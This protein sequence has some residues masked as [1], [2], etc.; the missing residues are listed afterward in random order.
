MQQAEILFFK[1]YN[2][3]SLVQMVADPFGYQPKKAPQTSVESLSPPSVKP[4]V[5]CPIPKDKLK[6]FA[7]LC[8]PN[9]RE[10]LTHS[11]FS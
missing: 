11:C 1:V 8:Q 4:V 9:Q 7:S 5:Y 6:N 3:C 2:V 10:L